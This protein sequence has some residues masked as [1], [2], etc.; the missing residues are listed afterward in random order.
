MA[1]RAPRA[2]AASLSGLSVRRRLF[3][4]ATCI[5]LAG[6]LARPAAADQYDVL[7]IV[8]GGSVTYDSNLF[9]L[10]GLLFD[11]QSETISTAYAKLLIDKPYGQQRFVVD[12]TGTVYRYDR[13]SQLDFTGLDYRAAWLWHVTPRVS[14]TLSADR[15][16]VPVSFE[17]S[18]SFRRNVRISERRAFT[19]DGWV[20]GGWH[21]LLGVRQ[22]DQTSEQLLQPE[23]DFREY[24]GELGVKYAARSG[25]SISLTGRSTDGNY[26]NRVFNVVTLDDTGFR[27]YDTELTGSWILG[28]K[29]DLFGR[30]TYLDRRHDHFAQR[31]FSG[32]AGEV[33]YAWKPTSKLSLNL[34]ARREIVPW[35]DLLSNY[36]V[37]NVLSFAPTWRATAKTTV[38]MR[39]ARTYSNFPSS[40]F[41]AAVPERNDTTSLA[42]VGVDWSPLR[43]VSVNA[44]LQRQIRSSSDPFVEYD[45]T[46]AR[47]GASLTF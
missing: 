11:P 29:S 9:R 3:Q 7:N 6:F 39:L 31:D 16:E 47:I 40:P 32:T 33:R 30:L 41:L 42:L 13:F 25:S 34:S 43:N 1:A 38:Q 21:L 10:P 46:I 27:Q 17:D 19:L 5:V 37:N 20:T 14:G 22:S 4:A 26:I 24:T 23:S 28:E 45:A 8:V 12:V 44:S 36:R 35:Q 18:R 2:L 15:V